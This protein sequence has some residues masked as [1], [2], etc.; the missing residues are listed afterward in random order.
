[1]SSLASSHEY[2]EFKRPFALIG[3]KY[4]N[5]RL[6]IMSN[7]TVKEHFI[8]QFIIN[9]FADSNNLIGITNITSHPIKTVVGKSANVFCK[10]NMYEFTNEDGSYFLRNGTENKFANLEGMLSSG[11]QRIIAKIESADTLDGRADTIL[12]LLISLQLV[13]TPQMKDIVFNNQIPTIVPSDKP[14]FDNAIYLMAIDSIDKGLQYLSNNGLPISDYGVERLGK[15]SLLDDV[16]CFILR[17]CSFYIVK[18]TNIHFV[19]TDNPILI[20]QFDDALYLFPVTPQYAIVCTRLDKIEERYGGRVH[21]IEDS[22]TNTLNKLM[23]DNTDRIIVYNNADKDYVT[24]TLLA[25]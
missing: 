21:I 22:M 24:K 14:L 25:H 16:A 20:G 18:T 1:M 12:A 6:L 17:D 19:L 7:D 10:K 13:R 23:I 5:Y 15:K 4:L 2:E 3:P 8:P 11:L 9:N